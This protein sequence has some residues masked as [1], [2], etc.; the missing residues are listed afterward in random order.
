M[1]QTQLTPTIQKHSMDAHHHCGAPLV[2]CA[3]TPVFMCPPPA[4]IAGTAAESG[5]E[6]RSASLRGMWAVVSWNCGMYKL[7]LLQRR[8]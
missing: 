5:R 3:N 6:C 4:A 7:L 8:R 2:S 1:K